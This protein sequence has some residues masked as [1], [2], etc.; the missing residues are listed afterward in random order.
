[1]QSH[2]GTLPTGLPPVTRSL[3]GLTPLLNLPKGG[4]AH[5]R[6]GPPTS[7]IN[8]ENAAQIFYRQ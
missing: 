8:Q 7:I 5:R 3:C 2:G 1:M 6:L 4:T